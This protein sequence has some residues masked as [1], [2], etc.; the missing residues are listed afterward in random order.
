MTA[1]TAKDFYEPDEN[2]RK[3]CDFLRG[4]EG[5]AVR[6]AIEMDKRVTYIKGAL[7]TPFTNLDRPATV[8]VRSVFGTRSAAF[9]A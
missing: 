6:E 4:S 2:L 5:P 3:L 1:A 9:A 8:F 7:S